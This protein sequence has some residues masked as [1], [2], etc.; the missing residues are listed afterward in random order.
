MAVACCFRAEVDECWSV[1]RR[2][3]FSWCI[4]KPSVFRRFVVGLHCNHIRKVVF[5][6]YGWTRKVFNTAAEN[7][8][9]WFMAYQPSDSHQS[10]HSAND[11]SLV[12]WV[13][14]NFVHL[15]RCFQLQVCD[16]SANVAFLKFLGSLWNSK[17]RDKTSV[18]RFSWFLRFKFLQK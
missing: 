2:R 15:T 9:H 18:F 5:D 17:I 11:Y 6:C 14:R 7:L 12:I 3:M 8:E 10:V 4:L 13:V 16:F 1:S